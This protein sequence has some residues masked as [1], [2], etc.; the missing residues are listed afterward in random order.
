[1]DA[2][3]KATGFK[4]NFKAFQFFLRHDPRFYVTTREALLEKAS[5]LAKRPTG[6]VSVPYRN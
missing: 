2:Q 6:G 3:I 1:M 5:R 4:G